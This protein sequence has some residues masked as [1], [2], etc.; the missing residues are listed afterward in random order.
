MASF[1]RHKEV[2]FLVSLMIVFTLVFFLGYA[3]YKTNK[4]IINIGLEAQ[5]ID[6]I[7]ML[8]CVAAIARIV[9]LIKDIEISRSNN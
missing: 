7:V 9:L 2:I 6:W 3:S 5:I 4:A 1:Y 8:F